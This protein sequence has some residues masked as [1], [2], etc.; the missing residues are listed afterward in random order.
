MEP[1]QSVVAV[2][3]GFGRKENGLFSTQVPFTHSEA[4]LNYSPFTRHTPLSTLLINILL[5]M[6][7][8]NNRGKKRG[9]SV[10]SD[11][12]TL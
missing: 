9:A 1:Q 7:N 10:R 5:K 4:S 6:R 12:F 8:N 11:R 3:G 2:Y